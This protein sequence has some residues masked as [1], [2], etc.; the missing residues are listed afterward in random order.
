MICHLL[1]SRAEVWQT[2]T[3][4]ERKDLRKY[5]EHEKPQI[6]TML[7]EEEIIEL[8]L[9]FGENSGF[10]STYIGIQLLQ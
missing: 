4:Y 7:N 2:S 10:T 1:M 6:G 3:V 9:M 8:L 5:L